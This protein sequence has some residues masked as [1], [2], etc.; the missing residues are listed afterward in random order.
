MA[1]DL[2]H[3]EKGE[4][5][6]DQEILNLNAAEKGGR[7][8]EAQQAVERAQVDQNVRNVYITTIFYVSIT[9]Q[10]ALLLCA[11]LPTFIANLALLYKLNADDFTMEGNKKFMSVIY[12]HPLSVHLVRAFT[13]T[14]ALVGA[15]YLATFHQCKN[16]RDHRRLFK[17]FMVG[18]FI[19]GI[20]RLRTRTVE[21][22]EFNNNY[23]Q[24]CKVLLLLMLAF[25]IIYFVWRT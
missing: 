13:P 11:C 5:E 8:A 18:Q 10:L 25:G 3:Q 15:T 6:E 16:D 9:M 20:S 23:L 12:N 19:F 17:N 14:A 21:G 22:A 24:D 7:D 2:L 1:E 4:G